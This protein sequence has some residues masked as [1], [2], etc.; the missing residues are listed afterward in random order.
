MRWTVARLDE[1]VYLRVSR[2][3]EVIGTLTGVSGGSIS[4]NLNTALKVSGTLDVVD[5][6]IADDRVRIIA[7]CD[8]G[9]GPEDVVLGTFLASTPAR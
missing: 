7:R 5:T 9:G 1:F 4:E 6:D 2:T 3:G 8:E